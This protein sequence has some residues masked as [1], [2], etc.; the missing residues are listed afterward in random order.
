MT[1]TLRPRPFDAVLA[2]ALFACAFPGSMVTL[3]GHDLRVSWWPGV[4]LAGVACLA[5]LWHR[6]RPR[7]TVAVTLVCAAAS[8]ALGYL[9]TVLLLGPLMVA[10]YSL[11]VRTDRRTANTAAGAAIATLVITSLIAGPTDEPL[12]LKLLGPTAWL[13]LPTSLGTVARLRTAYLDAVRARAEDAERTREEEAR[14]RVAEER[15]RIA[16]DLHDVV[17]HHLVL[18]NLQA[19]AVARHLPAR[20]EEAGRLALDLSGTTAAAMRELKATVG[21]LR[22]TVDEGSPPVGLAR[23]PDLAA[24]FRHAGLTVNVVSEGEPQPLP[25]GADLTA[26]RIVQ[27]ALTN[28]T[29][30]ADTHS[31]E[32]RLT[33]SP[34]LLGITVTNGGSVPAAAVQGGYGLVGMGE[35]A[36]SVGGRVRAGRRPQGG[37]EV[38][39]ELPVRPLEHPLA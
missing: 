8:S 29:K 25:A 28:V 1:D 36:L 16:R 26:Y 27:E 34:G 18:A 10:L 4:L 33:Y 5:L 38:V 37:F 11:A 7:T 32:V 19:G 12:V 24:S 14:R 30:H 23:L 22:H 15:V 39:A 20:P 2:A 21:L 31:A 13:L 35:R 9:L 6:D 17:A 3:P